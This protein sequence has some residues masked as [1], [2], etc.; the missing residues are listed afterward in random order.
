MTSNILQN[1][2]QQ[3]Y[4]DTTQNGRF[5]LSI[6]SKGSGKSYLLTSYL[7]M[8]LSQNIYKNIHFVCPCYKGEQNDSYAFLKNQKHVLVYDH[9]TEEVTKRVDKDRAKGKTLFLIDDAS[10]ELLHNIDNSFI[11]LITTTRHFKGCTVYVCVHSAKKILVPIVR[12]NIDHLFIYRIINM[13]LLNDLYDE[14]ISMMFDNFKEFKNFYTE[15]TQETNTCVHFSLH[16]PGL[17]IDVKN[18]QMNINKEKITLKPTANT[19]IKPKTEEPKPKHT[20]GIKLYKSK[21][22]F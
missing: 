11:Q 18:W 22:K 3:F 10:G 16:M 1:H 6:G 20:F 8:V 15:A 14:Y 5:I 19:H 9:Y 21:I 13:K 2:E 4:E 12:Q 17:D 7:K